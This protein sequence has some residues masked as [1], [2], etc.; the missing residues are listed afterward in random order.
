MTCGRPHAS[1]MAKPQAL[2]NQTPVFDK[3]RKKRK[4]MKKASMTHGYYD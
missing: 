3:K 4:K 1:G 2:V